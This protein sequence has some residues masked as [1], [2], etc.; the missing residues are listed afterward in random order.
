ML[1]A[2]TLAGLEGLHAGLPTPRIVD[3]DP[4]T[5]SEAERA[6]LGLFRLPR[7]LSEA[8]DALEADARV[9][10]WLPPL[11]LE[12]YVGLKRTEIRLA[13]GLDDAALCRRYGAVY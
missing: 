7:S 10:S 9:L 12:T 1:A 11:L 13:E 2:L 8:L 3:A 6:K 4:T 5:L